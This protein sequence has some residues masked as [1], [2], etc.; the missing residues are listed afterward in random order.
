[1]ASNPIASLYAGA[2]GVK[3]FAVTTLLGEEPKTIFRQGNEDASSC[4]AWPGSRWYPWIGRTIETPQGAAILRHVYSD[5]IGVEIIPGRMHFLAIDLDTGALMIERPMPIVYDLYLELI[6][7]F[8][9]ARA[10]GNAQ[11]ATP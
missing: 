2:Q 6:L 3:G 8:F 10:R 1:M 11:G 7:L 5:S 9:P 4:F